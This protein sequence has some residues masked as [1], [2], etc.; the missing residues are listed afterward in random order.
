MYQRKISKP[1]R[2]NES[3][4]HLEYLYFNATDAILTSY[5]FRIRKALGAI[6]LKAKFTEA[7]LP[8]LDFQSSQQIKTMMGV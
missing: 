2:L 1:S 7:D 6:E 4:N 3:W 5:W 8:S